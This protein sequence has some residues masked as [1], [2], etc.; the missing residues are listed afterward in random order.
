MTKDQLQA[1]HDAAEELHLIAGAALDRALDKL[2]TAHVAY[3]IARADAAEVCEECN[4][5]LTWAADEALEAR[6][7]ALDAVGTAMNAHADAL[8]AWGPLHDRLKA[9]KSGELKTARQG[10]LH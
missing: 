4:P 7:D 5:A 2:A 8:D 3:R 10:E 1:E 9:L 6:D